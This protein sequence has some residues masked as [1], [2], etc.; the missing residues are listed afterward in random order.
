MDT[1]SSSTVELL[2]GDVLKQISGSIDGNGKLKNVKLVL[3]KWN[4]WVGAMK[5][6]I[7]AISTSGQ[8]GIIALSPPKTAARSARLRN[9]AKQLM[10]F[11]LPGATAE[12]F[13]GLKVRNIGDPNLVP[14]PI[15]ASAASRAKLKENIRSFTSVIK[16]PYVETSRLLTESKK[17]AVLAGHLS[18]NAVDGGPGDL[19]CA[20]T[21]DEMLFDTGAQSCIVTEDFLNDEFRNFLKH[22]PI[23]EEYRSASGT[24]VQVDAVLSFADRQISMS[25]IFRVVPRASVPNQRVGIILGQFGFIDQ[26]MYTAVPRFILAEGGED[27]DDEVWGDLIVHRYVNAE[28]NIVDLG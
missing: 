9:N 8:D 21:S 19:S 28:W 5:Q 15:R 17:L 22:D 26:L 1:E 2:P 3:P 14:R 18:L 27:V 11:D 23:H 20:I 25:C 24:V 16:D 6:C 10:T 13:P 12:S 7:D 4:T